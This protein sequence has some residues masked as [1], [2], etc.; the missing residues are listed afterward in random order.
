MKI[1]NISS[2]EITSVGGVN[3]SIL[4]V[5]EELVKR[6]HECHVIN[7]S[8]DNLPKE[9]VINGINIIR[10]KSPLSKYLYQFSLSMAQFLLQYLGKNMKP[11]IIHIHEYRRLL[12]PEIAFILKTR[13]LP[14]IFSPHYARD[15]YS[16]WA[17]KYL[18]G[19]YK[20]FGKRSFDWSEEI[21]VHS[22][23]TKNVLL[24]DFNIY[25]RKINVVPH[26]I[27]TLMFPEGRVKKT[28]KSSISLLYA[29][30]LIEKKG[31]HH[32]ILALW[33]M[34]KRGKQASLT[35]IGKG[36]Y[37]NNL[38]ILAKKLG[39]E[40]NIFWCKP[41]SRDD[42]YLKI[43]EADVL[44]LLSRAEAYGIIVAEALAVGTPC[45][46]TKTTSLIEFLSEPGCFGVDYPPNPKQVA[47]KIIE[48][49]DKET[50][51]GPFSEKIRAWDKVTIEYERI[52]LDTIT[53]IQ[54]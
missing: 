23:Y 26:G 5:A 51:V 43:I 44:L 36:N 19:I 24:E 53:K 17:G 14:F 38:K 16:T 52:Y 28:R 20:P 35:I 4:K 33:E 42:L 3:F 32:V 11:D 46:V 49:H 47:D 10:I 15:E 7:I 21:I 12:T 6:G 9:E 50:K 29:G 40:N 25:P 22:G 1:L 31:I 8:L 34:K 30:V 13:H 18:L 45:I 54:H 27:D 41:L 39:V 2:T 37:E 48:I